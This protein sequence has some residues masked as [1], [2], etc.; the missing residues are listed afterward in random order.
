MEGL[1][2]S[3]KTCLN[4]CPPE[5]N[6]VLWRTNA[7]EIP[8]STQHITLIEYFQEFGRSLTANKLLVG[9]KVQEPIVESARFLKKE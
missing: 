4:L 3:T 7:Q 2:F 9:K 5:W 6:N 8:A 1:V